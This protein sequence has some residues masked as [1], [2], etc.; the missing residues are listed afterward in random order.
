MM[1]PSTYTVALLLAVLSM[2]CWGSWANTLKLAGKWR[3]ELYYFDYSIGVLLAATIAA[4]TFGS[5]DGVASD[6]SG[7]AF[8]FV[9]NLT[10]ASKAQMLFA[11]AAGIIFNLANLLLVAAITVAGLSVAF[12]V[13][14][15]LALIVGTVLNHV[16][17]PT[18]NPV[19]LFSGMGFILLAIIVT[20][21]AHAA[22]NVGRQ[23]PAP[24][25]AAEV[26]TIPGT[27]AVHRPTGVTR[28]A[29]PL[30]GIILSLFAGILMGLF[31]PLVELSKKGDLGL[32]PYTAAFLFGMGVLLSTPVFNIFFMNM[33]VEGPALGLRDYFHGTGRQHLLGLL[34]GI[35]WAVG[36]IANF[37]ASSTPPSVNV[38]PATSYAMG[39]GATLVSTLWGLLLW[40]EF[41]GASGGVRVR[42]IL[43]FVLFVVGLALLSLAPLR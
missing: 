23:A 4:F 8:S 5:T 37:V 28:K 2:I 32:G 22:Y 6:F 26:K 17:R 16:L 15:G 35:I 10:V 25:P 29:S 20:A 3:F 9:D 39:Q 43:M 7:P 1:I 18:G 40:K 24:A 21:M 42:L 27:R 30:K 36:C 41:A 13:G 11:V 12:P 14:I 38:G 33:P 34:G 31:Y 19:Y